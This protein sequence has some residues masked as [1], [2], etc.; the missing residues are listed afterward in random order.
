MTSEGVRQVRFSPA[1]PAS[2]MMNYRTGMMVNPTGMSSMGVL[3]YDP[4]R[5]H[6]DDDGHDEDEG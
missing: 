5:Q 1:M 4:G 3:R 6:V 2:E